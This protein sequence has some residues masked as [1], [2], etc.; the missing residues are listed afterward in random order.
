MTTLHQPER[1]VQSIA[2]AVHE[3]LLVLDARLR[4]AAANKVFYATFKA[5]PAE[6]EGSLVYALDDGDWDIPQLH[7]LLDEVIDRHAVADNFEVQHDFRSLGRKVLLLNARKTEDGPDGLIVLTIQDVTEPREAA[8]QALRREREQLSA[9]VEAS[10]V[11]VLLIEAETGNVLVSNHEAE[12]VLGLTFDPNEPVRRFYHAAAYTRPDGTAYELED[13]PIYRALHHGERVQGAEVQIVL[14]DGQARPALVNANPIASLDGRIVAGV[15]TVEDMTPLQ[16]AQQARDEFLY[17]VSH[18]MR[19]PIIALQSGLEIL[20]DVLPQD[21]PDEVT[22]VVGEM[23]QR[24]EFALAVVDSLL[25]NAQIEAGTFSVDRSPADVGAVIEAA[26][27]RVTDAEVSLDMPGERPLVFLDSVRIG[28]VMDNLLTNGVR[29]KLSAS[30]LAVRVVYS[31]DSVK[32]G[33]TNWGAV[34]PAAD[35][36]GLFEKFTKMPSARVKQGLGAGLGLAISKAIIEAHG[37]TIWIESDEVTPATTFSFT[38]PLATVGN[39][40]SPSA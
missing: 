9:V 20:G 33:V 36:E 24:T 6:T 26:C 5:I 12:R 16:D 21:I 17:M 25:D 40:Y 32:V 10:P 37:G 23:R 18:D 7:H 14:P 4:V 22:E 30:E 13:I 3:P 2:D 19:S 29:H 27:K 39:V 28:Q 38:L 31:G 1:L 34:I 11:G 8:E 35:R 15:M